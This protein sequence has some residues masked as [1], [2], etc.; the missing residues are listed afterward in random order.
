MMEI[1]CAN[2]TKIKNETYVCVPIVLEFC[3]LVVV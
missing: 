1:W 2:L 3:A